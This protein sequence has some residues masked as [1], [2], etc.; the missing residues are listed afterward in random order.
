MN[1]LETNNQHPL[2]ILLL[3]DLNE[4]IKLIE[5]EIKKTI[6]DYKLHV[7][8]NQDDF[9]EALNNFKPN[10]ILSD[11]LLPRFRGSDALTIVQSQAPQIPFVFVTGTIDDEEMAA[12]TIIDGASGFLLKRNLGRLSDVM[13]QA[14]E[15][16]AKQHKD[17][18]QLSQ[19][20]N[21]V[22]QQ[23]HELVQYKKNLLAMHKQLEALQTQLNAK[24][25]AADE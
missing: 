5:R 14:L 12:Q 25:D 3:E 15:L 23:T 7:V 11:Y 21:Q 4:D 20:Q 22:E 13:N 9:E 8:K 17:E 6:P 10:L 2:R 1:P 18:Q 24:Q 19:L 16:A